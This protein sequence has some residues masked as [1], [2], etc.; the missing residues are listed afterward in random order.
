[1]QP[2]SENA[3]SYL[4]QD[5]ES[6]ILGCRTGPGLINK[7]LK[8]VQS[9]YSLP[10]NNSCGGLNGTELADDSLGGVPH[11]LTF[12]VPIFIVSWLPLLPST[13]PT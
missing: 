13:L 5:A 6:E 12:A 11:T 7:H 10:S 8:E 1:M 2:F 3:R 9:L 4:Y